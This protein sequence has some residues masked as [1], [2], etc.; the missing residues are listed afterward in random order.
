MPT[1]C[2]IRGFI[3]HIKKS[4][5]TSDLDAFRFKAVGEIFRCFSLVWGKIFYIKLFNLAH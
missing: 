3:Y 5:G 1:S 4:F 2:R